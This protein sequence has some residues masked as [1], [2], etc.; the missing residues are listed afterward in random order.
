MEEITM[1]QSMLNILN[2]N[3]PMKKTI[4]EILPVLL[5]NFDLNKESSVYQLILDNAHNVCNQLI[6]NQNEKNSEIL[7]EN[8][9][10][11]F[12]A[13]TDVIQNCNINDIV[14]L[15]EHCIQLSVN[16]GF[17]SYNHKQFENSSFCVQKLY[18]LCRARVED[19]E[20]LAG[21]RSI[22]IDIIINESNMKKTQIDSVS[23]FLNNI[24]S[25]DYMITLWQ[26][27]KHIILSYPDRVITVLYNLQCFLLD[28]TCA[29]VVLSD[30]DYWNLICGLLIHDNTVVRGYTNAVLKASCTKFLSTNCLYHPHVSKDEYML[31][32]NDYVVVMETLENS[33]QHLVLPVLNTS[34]I[35]ALSNTTNENQN[36]VY[37]IPLNWITVMQ[38]KMSR[39]QSKHVVLASID[40][41]TNLAPST[42]I[43]DERL[44]KSFV[45]SLNNVFLY[46]MSNEIQ[47][48]QPDMEIILTNWFDRLTVSSDGIHVIDLFLSYV[49]IVQWSP[50]PLVFVTKSLANMSVVSP[51]ENFNS[52]VLKII[53]IS[54]NISNSYLK[55]SIQWFLFLFVSKFI[56]IPSTRISCDLFKYNIIHRKGT[57]SCNF[58]IDTFKKISNVTELDQQLTQQVIT[59]KSISATT[60]GLVILS[61]VYNDK[62]D[63][64]Q[65]LN[66]TLHNC[67]TV[68]MRVLKFLDCLMERESTHRGCDDNLSK[69][70][71]ENV[72]RLTSLWVDQC[73]AGEEFEDQIVSDYLDKTLSLNRIPYTAR[74]VDLMNS[75]LIKCTYM[76]TN[77]LGSYA[78]L[79]IFSLIGKYAEKCPSGDQLLNAWVMSTNSFIDDGYFSNRKK[80]FYHSRKPGSHTIPQLEIVSTYVQH[81]NSVSQTKILDL[82][83]WIMDKTVENRDFFWCSYLSAA[84]ICLS[85]YP[86]QKH[87]KQ[88][89]QFVEVCWDFLT[90]CRISCFPN[91]IRGFIQLAFQ[92]YLLVEN[93]YTN[94]IKNQI[95]RQLLSD[96]YRHQF[97]VCFSTLFL[98]DIINGKI[99][100][101]EYSNLY[102]AATELFANF[103]MYG[104]ERYGAIKIEWDT[105]EYVRTLKDFEI[106]ND[107]ISDKN[108]PDDRRLRFNT[109]KCLFKINCNQMWN[110]VIN[111]VIQL[112]TSLRDR[113]YFHNSKAYK[114]KQRISQFLLIAV[115]NNQELCSILN[116]TVYIWLLSSLKEVS[117]IHSV[118]YQIIWLLVLTYNN[119]HISTDLWND[120][121]NAQE[122]QN[123]LCSFISIIY[124]LHKI[125]NDHQFANQAIYYL[126]PLCFSNGYKIRFYAQS[127][128]CK[129]C[130]NK[131]NE[132]SIVCK[133]MEKT[134]VENE[135]TKNYE[136]PFKDFF[137]QNVDML[138]S[139][140]LK[141]ICIELPRLSNIV[142]EER[143]PQEWFSDF[144]VNID[145]DKNYD[146]TTCSLSSYIREKTIP[147]IVSNELTITENTH[148]AQRKY[149]PSHPQDGKR[150]KS[151]LIVVASLIDK[152]TNL[153]GLARTSQVFGASTLVV[154][155]L[156]CVE[157]REFTALS[158]TAEKH[159]DIVEV[160]I[161]NLKTY[162][163]KLKNEGYQVIAAEQTVN[164]VQ[165]H[166]AKLSYK[167]VLVLGNETSGMPH[168]LL[169][170]MD[171]C[172]EIKQLGIVRSLNVHVAGSLF[173]WE[174]TKQHCLDPIN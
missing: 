29:S 123:Y 139:L 34:K 126:L 18:N 21:L 11:L 37:K 69:V 141:N 32:W 83:Q 27:I 137:F 87:C 63:S 6:N 13:L 118:A 128:V 43:E 131:S 146:L 94:F 135:Q 133:A 49:P 10:S 82:F 28:P 44:M 16:D 155:N 103:I 45:I 136:N 173:I 54:Q 59:F 3:S 149:I 130:S 93:E 167:C 84:S 140:S 113:K 105:L 65:R 151:A 100:I 147:V 70:L 115:S 36:V 127:T 92:D 67:E 89:V 64:V 22:L 102:S 158:M 172:V 74:T 101:T 48:D 50:V 78:V 168:D 30:S 20:N 58:I 96:Q 7:S 150:N 104:T 162:L 76:L 143:F 163:Q 112:E 106:S 53:D 148:H 95:F 1:L 71:D 79:A 107:I 120:F 142:Y 117:H 19:N 35:L 17:K 62:I 52:R 129:L 85:K 14:L 124:H 110:D 41:V 109:I 23:T 156:T 114:I 47:V 97:C 46:K 4:V 152:I 90:T 77:N 73:F 24:M 88:V 171:T 116:D 154:D 157:K 66:Q 75:W 86:V 91:S 2:S 166:E 169:S 98:D 60:V 5:S 119:T 42:L 57:K 72:W 68:T 56:S 153:G 81:C 31:L 80:H 144:P 15:L 138:N 164:S 159:L 161:K 61:D 174:Y 111:I 108:I 99:R 160:R 33:Q 39:H 51:C 132:W 122:N 145:G 134:M 121:K 40:I 125:H 25:T 26:K 55:A 9:K 12:I 8:L 165:L 170:M 38:C